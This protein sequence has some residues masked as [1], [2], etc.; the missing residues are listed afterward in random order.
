[1]KSV[2]LYLMLVGIPIAG[3]VGVLQVGGSI[4]PPPYVGGTWAVNIVPDSI[5]G[6]PAGPD[7]LTLVVLQSG[8]HVVVRFDQPTLPK[9]RGRTSG[10]YF[11]A[12]SADGPRM[13]AAMKRGE[14]RMRGYLSGVPCGAARRT[15]FSG[16][17]VAAPGAVDGH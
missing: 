15:V 9:L 13:H 10:Q 2:A 16:T 12:G 17:R 5:C 7:S 11:R 4:I 1:M 14:N 8:S 6:S 3:V